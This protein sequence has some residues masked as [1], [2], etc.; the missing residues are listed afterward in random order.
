MDTGEDNMNK[1]PFYHG[2]EV[3]FTATEEFTESRVLELIT[4]GLES[5]PTVV[6]GSVE[7][8]EYDEPE[9]GDPADLMD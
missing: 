7:F 9:P 5:D 4:K 6:K 3:M 1:Q 2:C 8:A